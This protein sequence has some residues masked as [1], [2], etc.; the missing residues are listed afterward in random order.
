MPIYSGGGG[1]GGITVEDDPSALKMAQNLNDLADKPT[2]RTNLDVYSTSDTSTA[3]SN[4]ISSISLYAPPSVALDWNVTPNYT[5]VRSVMNNGTIIALNSGTSGPITIY[6]DVANG[7]L[8]GDRFMFL[9]EGGTDGLIDV[10]SGNY[11]NGSGSTH[12]INGSN[13]HWVTLIANNGTAA[14]WSAH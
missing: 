13:I 11:I 10:G 1:V 6:P 4:A 3:I 2:A 12:A 9:V 14:T 5:P 8:V 7:W